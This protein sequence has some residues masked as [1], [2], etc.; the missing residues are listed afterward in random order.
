M[1][2]NDE[3]AVF[4]DYSYRERDEQKEDSRWVHRIKT[5]W[6]AKL[7]APQKEVNEF[8][9]KVIKLRKQEKMLG[10]TEIFFYDVQDP[11]VF[12]FRRGTIHVVVNFSERPANVKIDAWA[13]ES[14]DLLT[15]KI[16]ENYFSQNLG[17][18]EVRWLSE[19]L[20]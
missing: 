3:K 9:K 15:G 4:N 12:A 6:K 10:G 2:A 14:K 13:K 18:Y 11:A 16:Y 20:K 1:Y 17:P 19:I 7:L 8:L 5:D